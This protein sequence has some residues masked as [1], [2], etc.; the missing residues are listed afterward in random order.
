M[1]HAT[2][3]AAT[4]DCGG[5]P[6]HLA[7]AAAKARLAAVG[8]PLKAD[9]ACAWGRD[10]VG[11]VAGARPRRCALLRKPRVDLTPPRQMALSP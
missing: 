4:L 7:G 5:C 9:R 10:L 3:K 2:L 6:A 8:S 11:L 1:R